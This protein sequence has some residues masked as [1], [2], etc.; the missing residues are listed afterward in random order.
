MY[1]VP[2][3]KHI[4]IYTIGYNNYTFIKNT[5]EQFIHLNVRKIIIIDNNS[6]YPKLLDYYN[7]ING[8][9][10]NKTHINVIKMDKN[11][12]HCVFYHADIWKILP[13]FFVLTDPDLKYNLNMPKNFLQI[14]AAYTLKNKCKSA[15]DLLNNES[16]LLTNNSATYNSY[17][18]YTDTTFSLYNK[19]YNYQ[20]HHYNAVNF[21][22]IF[23]CVHI[24]WIPNF[25]E[26]LLE[27]EF[28][29]MINKNVCS[30]NFVDIDTSKWLIS[31]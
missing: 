31:P 17:F 5:V 6:F 21:N 23:N 20:G 8:K 9:I 3:S 16:E 25:K 27:D 18:K 24:P 22:G 11:Y 7:E 15:F 1:K 14:F 2:K 26:M 28:D 13:K 29:Y 12:G 4:P 10:I 19:K 30:S